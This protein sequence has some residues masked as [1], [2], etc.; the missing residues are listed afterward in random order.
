MKVTVLCGGV[1]GAKFLE[2]LDQWNTQHGSP[3]ELT[4]VVNVGDDFTHLG[5][6]VSP[7]IDSVVYR[8]AGLNNPVHGWGRRDETHRVA[9]E[10]ARHV[11]EVTWFELGDLDI[12]NCAMRTHLLNE[13][14][15]LSEVTAR[16]ASSYGVGVRV[17]PVTDDPVPTLVQLPAEGSDPASLSVDA[18]GGQG[19]TVLFQEWWVQRKAQPVPLGFVSHGAGEA[20]PAPGVLD[21]IAHADL[22]LIAPSNPVVSIT[23]LLAIP[24]VREAL[25][26]TSAR[27]VGLSPLIGGRPVRGY[28]DTCLAAV[29]VE[30]TSAGV[31]G[32]YGARQE[33]GLLDGWLI[34]AGDEQ[35]FAATSIGQCVS[36]RAL[37]LIFGQGNDEVIAASALSVDL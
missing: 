34:D 24:G 4:A 31:A 28:A 1:G 29:G 11:P 10:V 17:L 27:V 25:T 15:T 19:I 13:G 30:S 14:Q 32:M 5:L 9:Q 35:D 16:L 7:D 2:V 23:P 36:W 37:P 22:V 21:A 33:G 8:L 6:R 12:A 18:P 20:H 3:H 26:S